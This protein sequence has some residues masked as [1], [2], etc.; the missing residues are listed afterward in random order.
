MSTDYRVT[1]TR[2]AY[3]AKVEYSSETFQKA[4]KQLPLSYMGKIVNIVGPQKMNLPNHTQ[5]TSLLPVLC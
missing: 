2:F 4:K 3:Y 1:N 5:F